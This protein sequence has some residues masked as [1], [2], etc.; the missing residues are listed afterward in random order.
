MQKSTGGSYTVKSGD[1]L[2]AIA[3]AHGVNVNTLYTD[4]SAV[5]GGDIDLILP[6]QVLSI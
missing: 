6:G 2:N 3:A 4:N 5:I 1:T